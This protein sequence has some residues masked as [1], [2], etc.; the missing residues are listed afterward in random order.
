MLIGPLRFQ[1]YCRPMLRL[2]PPRAAHRVQRAH[3]IDART[4]RGSAGGPAGCSPTPGRSCCTGD[5]QL[6]AAVRRADAGQLQHLRRADGTGAQH[7]A[8]GGRATSMGAPPPA[9]AAPHPHRTRSRPRVRQHAREVRAGPHLQVGAAHHRPQEGLRRVP[10]DAAALVD[11]EVA[12]ALVV[13]AVEV[14]GVRDAGLLRG[15]AQT[16][17]GCPSAGAASRP[18]TRRPARPVEPGRVVGAAVEVL[19][20]Q[21]KRQAL[22][23]APAGVAE[24]QA[25][26]S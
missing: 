17:R 1:A 19:V 5:A 20:L 6:A 24:S 7:H 2:A 9:R 3:A 16:R 11:V 8:A 12:H 10:A 14:L 15:L 18:A 13:A 26:W 21:E 4:P 25:Q 23:P 22:V